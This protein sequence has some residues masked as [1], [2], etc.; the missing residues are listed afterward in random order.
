MFNL[1][2]STVAPGTDR[3]LL[4][5]RRPERGGVDHRYC[6]NR[7]KHSR[8][9]STAGRGTKTTLLKGYFWRL[10]PHDK[11]QWH[12]QLPTQVTLCGASGDAQANLTCATRK[13]VLCQQCCELV[14]TRKHVFVNIMQPSLCIHTCLAHDDDDLPSICLRQACKP[15]QNNAVNHC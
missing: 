13:R 15:K 6:A 4:L 14:Y 3:D 12:G 1:N 7:W 5:L 2:Q 8:L 11:Q 9:P 10:H